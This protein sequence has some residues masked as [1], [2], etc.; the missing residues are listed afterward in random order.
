MGQ[1]IDTRL[2]KRQ[3]LIKALIFVAFVISV[4]V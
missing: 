3:G 2:N 1:V 4:I